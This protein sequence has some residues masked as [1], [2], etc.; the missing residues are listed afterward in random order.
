M[1]TRF[2]LGQK[3]AT[4]DGLQNLELAFIGKDVLVWYDKPD[5][6]A[7]T[8]LDGTHPT[9]PNKNMVLKKSKLTTLLAWYVSSGSTGRHI[10]A[11]AGDETAHVDI[12]NT[13]IWKRITPLEEITRNVDFDGTF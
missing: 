11:P 9:D 13:G 10:I 2:Q 7:R 12:L 1:S 8:D 5:I 6:I 3:Y 4:A